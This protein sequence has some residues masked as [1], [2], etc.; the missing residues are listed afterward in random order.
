MPKILVIDDDFYV[1][2]TIIAFLEDLDYETAEADNGRV[3]LEKFAEFHPDLV[4]VDLRM[5]V[6]DGKEFITELKNISPAT[7]TIVVS[8]NNMIEE[9]IGAIRMGAWDYVTKPIFD[10]EALHYAIQRVLE[11]VQLITENTEYREILEEKNKQ[12]EASNAELTNV[13][14]KIR[15]DEEAGKKIQFQLL[16]PKNQIFDAYR[17]SYMLLPSA[18]VSGDFVDYF[19]IDACHLGFYIADVSGHGVSSAFVTVLLKSQVYQELEKYKSGNG[20]AIMN[21]AQ[22]LDSLNTKLIRE[23][24]SK[25]ITIFYG[26]IDE[27]DNTLCYANGGQYPFP[28]L[29]TGN[30]AS[31]IAQKGM[32][33]GI[34]NSAVYEEQTINLPDKFSLVMVSD[35]ILDIMHNI[36]LPQKNKNLLNICSHEADELHDI[37]LK[38]NLL[39]ASNFPDDITLL[40]LKK[41]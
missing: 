30:S 17:L 20:T 33:V 2:S 38:L 18:R 3:G 29:V 32:V 16:P 9:A 4:L 10:I 24:L 5:P 15:E 25:F 6:M 34:I 7:P 13:L 40:Q 36:E 27:S 8:A 39:Q 35:G 1:R 31:F 12:L 22:L 41:H 28:M 23:N 11:R 19:R 26:V 21:P 37:A 14:I